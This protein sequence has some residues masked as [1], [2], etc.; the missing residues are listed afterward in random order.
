MTTEYD[1]V[2]DKYYNTEEDKAFRHPEKVVNS[3]KEY[4]KKEL[5]TKDKLN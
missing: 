3:A 2:R 1:K 5:K 4:I